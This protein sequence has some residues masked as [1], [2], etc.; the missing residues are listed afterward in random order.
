MNVIKF[1]QIENY[2]NYMVSNMGH[3]YSK[4]SG[5]ILKPKT[6]RGYKRVKLCN[7]GTHKYLS[8]HRLV[9]LAFIPNPENKRQ[10]DHINQ[11]KENNS[12][13]NLRFCTH[14]ENQINKD[15]SIHNKSGHKNICWRKGNNKWRVCIKRNNKSKDHGL[16][17]NLEDAIKKRDEIL[18]Q[19]DSKNIS[20]HCF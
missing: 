6:D 11:N 15:I 7:N 5:K 12:I 20:F 14:T 4:T 1:K 13:S 2:P 17:E 16:F 18:K 8:V 3:I 19:K 10:V 9:A